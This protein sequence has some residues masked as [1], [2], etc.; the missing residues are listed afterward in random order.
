MILGCAL[1]ITLYNALV[2][3]PSALVALEEELVRTAD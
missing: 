3:E 1:S 2:L